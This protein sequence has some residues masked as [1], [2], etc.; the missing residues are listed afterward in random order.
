MGDHRMTRKTSRKRLGT[1]STEQIAK[2]YASKLLLEQQI[3][4][5]KFKSTNQRNLY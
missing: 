5:T 2:E 4:N 1:Q 3:A